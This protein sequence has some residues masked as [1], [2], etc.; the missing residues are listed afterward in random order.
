MAPLT[1]LAPYTWRNT[2]LDLC[3]TL[4]IDPTATQ[5][6]F[7][8]TLCDDLNEFFTDLSQTPFT[9]TLVKE[10]QIHIAF[11]EM[12]EPGGGWPEGY[13]KKAELA[14]EKLEKEVGGLKGLGGGLWDED[15]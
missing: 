1:P 5:R 7:T 12:A 3:P 4:L 13:V 2:I 15:G 14:L 11:K 6:L 8:K 10:T 9:R